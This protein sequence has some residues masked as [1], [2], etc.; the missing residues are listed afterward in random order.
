MTECLLGCLEPR[1][2]APGCPGDGCR[3]C[4][5]AEARHGRVC[6]N[7]HRRLELMLTDA[8][9]VVDWLRA[10]L[11]R[12]TA[13]PAQN[14]A[15]LR[16]GGDRSP[17]PLDLAIFDLV[18]VWEVALP[19][20]T[21]NLCTDAGLSGPD[22]LDERSCGRFLLTWL[23]TVET[24]GWVEYLI[25]ELTWLTRDSHAVAP[26]RPT[27]KR[28]DG[29]PCPRCHSTSLVVFGG[30][31]DVTCLDC[32]ETIPEKRYGIWTRIAAEEASA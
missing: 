16:R 19:G 1:A 28:V 5:P 29:V 24:M 15:E 21:E 20:W 14:D 8:P 11:A 7:C 12:G 2:H 31:S 10:H 9:T 23:S 6:W 17:V 26:W 3:G 25:E 18:D 30:E 13:Q 32:R 27:M 4:K 22:Q